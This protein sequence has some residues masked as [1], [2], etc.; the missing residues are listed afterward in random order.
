VHD[1]VEVPDPVMLVGVRVHVRVVV[2][3]TLDVKLT[4]P[5]NPFRE[6]RVM[7]DDPAAPAFTVTPVGLAD[8]VKSWTVNVTV[9]V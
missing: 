9:A 6:V 2:G 4:T 5:L 8:I 3:L 1:K 7:V